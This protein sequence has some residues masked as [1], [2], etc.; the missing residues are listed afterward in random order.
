MSQ[1]M[2]KIER[3]IKQKEEYR[4]RLEKLNKEYKH[5]E[6]HISLLQQGA[7]LDVNFSGEFI[8][9]TYEGLRVNLPFFTAERVYNILKDLFE[10]E[11]E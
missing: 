1:K 4:D 11:S 2:S 7:Y 8:S 6:S 5:F 10:K 9:I 3:L